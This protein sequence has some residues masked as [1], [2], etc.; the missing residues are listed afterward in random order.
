VAFLNTMITKEVLG[1]LAHEVNPPLDF[2]ERAN[3][4]EYSDRILTNVL[5]QRMVIDSI[6]ITEQD[7]LET[8]EQFRWEVRLKRIQFADRATA[9]RVR[10][11]LAAGRVPWS[12]AVRRY[13]TSEDRERDGDIGWR[14]R[15][16]VDAV[17]AMQ[18]FALS[19]G[20]ITEVISDPSGYQVVKLVERRPA[21]APALE[22]LRRSIHSQIQSQRAAVR[23]RKIQKDLLADLDVQY[24]EDNCT[25]A[26]ERFRKPVTLTADQSSPVLE[27]DPN[28]PE[29]ST[30]DQARVL[31]RHRS[32]EVTLDDLV[33][34]L[35]DMPAM[36]RPSLDTPDAVKAQVDA[37]ILDPTMVELA[38]AHGM[39]RD[40]LA[41]DLIDRKR[42]ELM[43]EHI[44]RDSIEANVHV[45]PEMRR[46]FY[47][48]NK[49]GYFTYP[50]VSF[51]ALLAK[52]RDEADSLKRVLETGADVAALIRADS[53]AG[54]NR[55]SIQQRRQNEQGPYHKLLLEEMRAGSIV[56]EG[57]DKQGDFVVL[58][59]LE[60]DG[61]RQLALAEVEALVDESVRNIESERRLKELVA[62]HRARY[63]VEAHPEKV[64]AID[65]RAP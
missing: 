43:V 62:R 18:V 46:R 38:V 21:V 57:P 19:P 13:S 45:T 27:I 6:I 31:A 20:Q 56:V 29:F 54:R 30:A 1:L 65:F 58:K 49:P 8:Y 23:T 16:G 51:A 37:I 24:E 64:M 34:A 5:Y 15:M 9:E 10:R 25:W 52:S 11:D 63:R 14:G 2:A 42:E 41:K 44:Y 12:V 47:E 48:D 59:L 36:L 7:I 17:L 28:L 55:G 39:D 50:S 26:S 32:G 61:G 40:P 4:R 53:L 33:H 22:P 35:H 3:L 60:Y